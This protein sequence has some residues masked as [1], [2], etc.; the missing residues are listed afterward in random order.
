MVII[1]T[2]ARFYFIP[3]RLHYFIIPTRARFYFIPTGDIHRLLILVNLSTA[4]HV[5]N[6]SLIHI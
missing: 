4:V 6:L 1:P 3:A 5:L 2:G